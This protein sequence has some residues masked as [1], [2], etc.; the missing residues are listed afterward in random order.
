MS[1]ALSLF[2][3]PGSEPLTLAQ[4]K[5][6]VGIDSTDTS[7]DTLLA[8][9]TT[10]ARRFVEDYTKRALFNQTWDLWLDGIPGAGPGGRG[11]NRGPWWDG[12]REGSIVA[13]T[14]GFPYIEIPK[15]PLS[16]ITSMTWYDLSDTAQTF[17]LT[18]TVTDVDSKPP[19]LILKVGATWPIGLR[20]YRSINIRFVAGYDVS[21][22]TK[23]PAAL[24]QA[25]R[26]LVSHFFE[27][28]EPLVE[29]RL[30]ECP[31]SVKSMLDEYVV[32]SL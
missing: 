20:P 14:G 7:N 8:D 19:R 1:T 12:V 31:L 9:L 27:N 32:R 17:D 22:A 4:A 28:R 29:G 5:A 24:L 6:Y 21:D 2:T 30:A 26:L 10:A 13:L 15:T 18:T 23:V 25:I 16:S 11:I 3:G